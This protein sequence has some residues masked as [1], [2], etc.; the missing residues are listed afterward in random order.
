MSKIFEMIIFTAGTQIYADQ[1]INIIE[2]KR[3]IFDMRL[4]RQHTIKI[5][6]FFVKDL[7]KLGRDLSKVIIIDNIPQSF[8]LQKENGI[9]IKKFN[10]DN[11]NDN[12]LNHLIPIL[13]K[14]TSNINNDVRIELEKFK[15]EIFS[16]ITINFQE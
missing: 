6:N 15:N 13:K 3:K 16:K 7:S 14:I 10:V 8:K 11:K 1:M 2:E 9:Y 5:D 12:A 4:Y